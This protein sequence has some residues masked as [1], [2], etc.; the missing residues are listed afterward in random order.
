MSDNAKVMVPQGYVNPAQY[1]TNMYNSLAMNSDPMFAFSNT[2]GGQAFMDMDSSLFNCP[3]GFNPSFGF[4]GFYGMG[5]GP[6]SEIFTKNMTQKDLLKYQSDLK[7]TQM[8]A[9]MDE[10]VDE[11]HVTDATGFLT[12]SDDDAFIRQVGILQR[13][14]HQKEQ[15]SFVKEYNKLQKLAKAKLE[16]SPYV[17]ERGGATAVEVRAYTEKL[18][19]QATG[20]SMVEEL[21]E[22]GNTP[23]VQGL[24]DGCFGIGHL[25]TDKKDYEDNISAITGEDTR[26]ESKVWRYTGAGVSALA[27]CGLAILGVVKLI[28]R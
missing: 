24:K 27:T 8:G 26:L 22:Y 1:Y 2:A 20:K 7:K 16:K 28:K 23:F 3:M 18:Y 5:Y 6:G 13:K 19:A 4:G 9:S 21:E 14:I 15:D 10:L 25:F 17:I 12:T 11:H